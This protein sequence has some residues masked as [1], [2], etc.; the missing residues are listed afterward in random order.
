MI[1]LPFLEQAI[2]PVL[3]SHCL[4]VSESDTHALFSVLANYV[5]SENPN[6]DAKWWNKSEEKAK[7]L[8]SRGNDSFKKQHY[9][10]SVRQYSEALRFARDLESRTVLH[11]NRSSAL[12]ELRRF[13]E[14]LADT[15]AAQVRNYD[16]KRFIHP[17]PHKVLL[18]QSKCMV[19][20][21]ISVCERKSVLD[22][23]E[24]ALSCAESYSEPEWAEK[25][26]IMIRQ[27]K[28]FEGELRHQS[29]QDIKS[30]DRNRTNVLQVVTLPNSEERYVCATC[31]M[32]IGTNLF[33]EEAFAWIVAPSANPQF[34]AHCLVQL[35]DVPVPCPCCSSVVL[36][37]AGCLA[38]SQH[39]RP[40]SIHQTFLAK[41][42]M[43]QQQSTMS[44]AGPFLELGQ[45]AAEVHTLGKAESLCELKTYLERLT[46]P[47]KVVFALLAVVLTS[48]DVNRRQSKAES[49]YETLSRIYYNSFAL[50]AWVQADSSGAQVVSRYEERC[51]TGLFLRASM[52]NH[53]CDSNARIFFT[54]ERGRPPSCAVESTRHIRQGESICLSYGPHVSTVPDR[55]KRRMEIG[56]KWQFECLCSACVDGSNETTTW[57][58]TETMQLPLGIMPKDV[59][60]R[61]ESDGCTMGAISGLSSACDSCHKKQTDSVTERRNKLMSSIS[62]FFGNGSS[63]DGVPELVAI[64]QKFETE[65]QTF[66]TS[67]N[68]LSRKSALE[69]SPTFRLLGYLHDTVA[70]RYA[71]RDPQIT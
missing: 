4:D 13:E 30:V 71:M 46:G 68:S 51:G 65:I 38:S 21:G 29:Q 39:A 18:R 54:F 57:N 64:I 41:L 16:T 9:Q 10:I 60:F 11:A 6:A 56:S 25:I 26:R 34:C 47:L 43:L 3:L 23:L 22:V 49:F 14:C 15:L 45:L 58:D 48:G 31:D 52:F 17:A 44:E 36:C 63:G 70:Q 55:A 33:S 61:C 53:S 2:P 28:S 1:V 20:L 37:S 27:T 12:F 50:K 69:L 24:E 8:K 40:R 35:N 59:R 67:E 32:Q 62:Q 5:D 42:S 19:E 7:K 66:P